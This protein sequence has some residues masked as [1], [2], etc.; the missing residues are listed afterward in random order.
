[1]ENKVIAQFQDEHLLPT[2]STV[3]Q[4]TSSFT[5]LAGIES[6]SDSGFSAGST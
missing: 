4:T 3:L 6:A 1:M 2:A 5:C